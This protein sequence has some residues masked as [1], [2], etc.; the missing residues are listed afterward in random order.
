MFTMPVLRATT[1]QLKLLKNLEC[2]FAQGYL[3]SEPVTADV[4]YK[5]FIESAF[6][7]RQANTD[8][9]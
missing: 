8:L 5:Q 2:D 4:F 3:I 9:S 7:K 6:R 1:A